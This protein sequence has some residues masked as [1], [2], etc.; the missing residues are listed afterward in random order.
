MAVRIRMSRFGKK[1]APF[2]RIVVADSRMKRDGRFLEKV[3]TYN[4]LNKDIHLKKESIEKWLNIGA[5]PSD[6]VAKLFKNENVPMPDHIIKRMDILQ[7][8]NKKVV[9]NKK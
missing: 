7:A 8:S 6:T 5:L 9:S 2:Y 4:P 1:R 3:G